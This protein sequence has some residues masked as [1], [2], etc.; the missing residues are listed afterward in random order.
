MKYK[1]FI[2]YRH[3]QPD[4]AAAK[5]IIKIVETYG[6]PKT[7]I[8]KHH[9]DKRVGKLF[10]DED[11]LSASA[12]LSKTITDALDESEYLIMI[13]SPEYIRSE[14][15]MLEF[16]YWLE[17]KNKENI[18]VILL[19]GEPETTF[20]EKLTEDGQPLAIDVRGNSE[21]KI[22][23]NIRNQK[24][25]IV[26]ALI[27]CDYDDL[28]QRD[29]EQAR[30]SRMISAGVL[31]SMICVFSASVAYLQSKANNELNEK[32]IQI[33]ENL[34][35]ISNQNNEINEKNDEL[36]TQNTE[37]KLLAAD[38]C[39]E[40]AA[41]LAE[42]K[43][44][45]DAA[46]KVLEAYDLCA[47]LGDEPLLD[48]LTYQLADY[49]NIYDPEKQ[50]SKISSLSVNESFVNY[51][52][53]G[54]TLMCKGI[55]V[56]KIFDAL[57][58][59]MLY[60]MSNLITNSLKPYLI[61]E[62]CL[63]V[64][65]PSSE[66]GHR[67]IHTYNISDGSSSSYEFDDDFGAV[68]DTYWDNDSITVLSQNKVCEFD[69]S[70]ALKASYDISLPEDFGTPQTSVIIDDNDLLFVKS[71]RM[72][73]Y[74]IK[75]REIRADIEGENSFFY[76]A[77]ED[78]FY[79][80]SR[81]PKFRP[82]L[83]GDL[84]FYTGEETETGFTGL[85][86]ASLSQNKNYGIA[87]MDYG[88][89]CRVA[90]EY[91]N[92]K[93]VFATG[94]LVN[95]I[96]IG[97]DISE[98]KQAKY[99][100]PLEE[101]GYVGDVEL[102]G[103]TVAVLTDSGIV[104][105]LMFD[106]T[107]CQYY[108]RYDGSY[109]D[110]ALTDGRIIFKNAGNALSVYHQVDVYSC[111]LMDNVVGYLDVSDNGSLNSSSIYSDVRFDEKVYM[112][113]YNYGHYKEW[114]FDADSCELFYAYEGSYDPDSIYGGYVPSVSGNFVIS[115][116]PNL[117]SASADGT[118]NTI[119]WK[120]QFEKYSPAG[121]DA[122]YSYMYNDDEYIYIMCDDNGERHGEKYSLSDGSP[123]EIIEFLSDKDSSYVKEYY[124]SDDIRIEVLGNNEMVIYKNNSE[125]ARFKI[126][127]GH[128]SFIDS[129]TIVFSCSDIE[130]NVN[131]VIYSLSELKELLRVD[132]YNGSENTMYNVKGSDCSYVLIANRFLVNT[133]T[134]KVEHDFGG[135]FSN[136]TVESFC[137]NEYLG[138][139]E[140]CS[141]EG[142]MFL[143]TESYECMFEV[144]NCC[145]ATP[146]GKYIFVTSDTSSFVMKMKLLSKEEILQA[147]REKYE[148]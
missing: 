86:A 69:F 129:D 72:L 113:K 81:R 44:Y 43:L 128:Y 57:T 40:N 106:D 45:D 18:I 80:S 92:N 70:C 132:G 55:D 31:L 77:Y 95:V 41:F 88:E 135:E 120:E 46:K 110:I 90:S 6:I 111:K 4:S 48:K 49:M 71:D 50:V 109:D 63:L 112:K 37:M 107:V 54:N 1:A 12:N 33:E 14:W 146:D 131:G 42:K 32:N 114:I 85:G 60:S 145:G 11:E 61:S 35:M 30:Q 22:L 25:R 78:S 139:W 76:N 21:K 144:K 134:L 62:N 119:M 84:L 104:H 2:S 19:D 147:A 124:I 122:Y 26:A 34:V 87:E 28:R 24:L 127:Y 97:E 64:I 137:F 133:E 89:Y 148:Q 125:A 58:G 123:A 117:Y 108:S 74:D 13:C 9:T 68:I 83:C 115:Q 5:N 23:R 121:E 51:E 8:E 136:Q 126:E 143:N 140:F 141:S 94:D 118:G 66:N 36:E 16:N 67:V 82:K 52:S 15:C 101:N 3:C 17:H 93:I 103:D 130:G 73:V 75:N 96:F 91:N 138:L 105:L 20:P 98:L 142:L 38:V 7:I 65:E 116:A 47:D 56:V 100:I 29:K 59:E 53:I 99:D 27:G 102:C 39:A 79:S 10:R